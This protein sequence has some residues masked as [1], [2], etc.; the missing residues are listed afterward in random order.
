MPRKLQPN[1]RLVPG[2]QLTKF[3]GRG[4]FGQVWAANG[5]GGVKVALKI[6]DME[7]GEGLKEFR[8][9]R[10]FKNIHHPNL[11]PIIGVWLRDEGGNLI[12]EDPLSMDGNESINLRSLRASEMILAMGLGDKNLLDLLRDF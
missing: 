5:P 4:G 7:G 12:E 11:A 2:Y 3:L 9:I 6:I 8:G 10:L 1:E